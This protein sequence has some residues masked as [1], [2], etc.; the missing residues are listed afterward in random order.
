MVWLEQPPLLCTVQVKRRLES[1]RLLKMPV[2]IYGVQT[3][4]L[5]DPGAAISAVKPSFIEA[6]N[7]ATEPWNE[8]IYLA[9]DYSVQ[10]KAVTVPVNIRTPD[11]STFSGLRVL[12]LM[13]ETPVL[14]GQDVLPLLGIEVVGLPTQ[15]AEPINKRMTPSDHE[16]VETRYGVVRPLPPEELTEPQQKAR[17]WVMFQIHEVI[18][19]NVGIPGSNYCVDLD[20]IVFVD[21]GDHRPVYIRQYRLPQATWED[22]RKQIILW[23]D[24]G[25]IMYAPAG[26]E[27]NSPILAVPKKDDEG[28]VTKVRV[29]LDVRAINN[30]MP[31]RDRFPI[32]VI[33]NVL[34][35][36]AGYKFYTKIDLESGYNQFLVHPDDQVKLAF[37]FEGNQYMFVRAPF[38]LKHLPSIF[39]RVMTRTLAGMTQVYVYIDDII[40][41]AQTKEELAELTAEVVRRLTAKSLRIKPSKCIWCV[42]RV[43]VLGHWVDEHTITADPRK[44]GNV[45][46]WPQPRSAADLRAFLG[47][48]GFLSDYVPYYSALTAPMNAIKNSTSYDFTKPFTG[49]LLESWEKTK[50]AISQAVPLAFPDFSK[51]FYLATDS[52][53]VGHGGV[54]YQLN[55]D[56][57]KK[58]IRF[59][60]RS[61]TQGERGY[62]ATELELAAIRYALKQCRFYL[63]GRPFILQTDH[64]ALTFMLTQRHINRMLERC[65]TEIMDYNFTCQHIPGAKLTLPDALSRL[66]PSYAKLPTEEPLILASADTVLAMDF[67]PMFSSNDGWTLAPYVFRKVDNH[68]GYGPH[69]VDGMATPQNRQ[70]DKF[71]C[72]Q[73]CSNINDPSAKWLGP[74]EELDFSKENV[75]INPPWAKISWVLNRVLEQQSEATIIIPVW[76]NARWF[77]LLRRM[78][79][80]PPINLKHTNDLF[81]PDD[82][83]GEGVGLPNWGAT[84]A[85]RISGKPILR[86]SESKRSKINRVLTRA[87]KTAREYIPFT[88]EQK[89][90]LLYKYHQMGHF[91][92]KQIVPRLKRDGYHWPHMWDDA[93]KFVSAC[94]Q[95]AQYNSAP[96]RYRPMQ[97]IDALLPFDHLQIDCLT[98]HVSSE[99]YIGVLVIIDV[100]SR[101]CWLRPLKEITGM[102]VGKE[103]AKIMSEY[104]VCKILQSDNG[105]EFCNDVVNGVKAHMCIKERLITPWNPRCD[106]G[107]ERHIRDV[108]AMVNKM[109][110]GATMDWVHFIPQ[111]QLWMNLRITSRYGSTPFT[112]MFNRDFN[113]FQD[114]SNVQ[115]REL[116]PDEVKERFNQMQEDLFPAIYAEQAGVLARRQLNYDANHKSL[117]NPFPNGALVMLEQIPRGNKMSPKYV[118]PFKIE[119]MTR[120]GSYVIRDLLGDLFYRN[121]S[122]DQLKMVSADT[123]VVHDIDT[124]F[125]VKQILN[126]EGTPGNYRY[127]LW[128]RG[129]PKKDA[130]WE[131][132]DNLNCPDLVRDYWLRIGKAIP[133]RTGETGRERR[134]RAPNK[135]KA[136]KSNTGSNQPQRQRLDPET[137][138][139]II[140]SRADSRSDVS[141]SSSSAHVNS[142]NSNR[143]N[144]QSAAGEVAPARRSLRST[145]SSTV[146]YANLVTDDIDGLG[147]LHS[148]VCIDPANP[149]LSLYLSNESRPSIN[150]LF[151]G[152]SS[153]TA[154][155]VKSNFKSLSDIV[156]IEDPLSEVQLM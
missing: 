106:G 81:S 151:S 133:W 28:N 88:E 140:N 80:E 143:T 61:L 32:P 15:W 124:G 78:L 51:T 41:A 52:S 46:D 108:K 42:P 144:Q 95:C 116:T 146:N 20:A 156:F 82:K 76:P 139:M 91:S 64:R 102:A 1:G 135:R 25:V 7:I 11:H 34:E 31:N 66:Y 105:P 70:L 19:E 111:V 65:Y 33:R 136:T 69:T 134:P 36:L 77:P 125:E 13:C 89:E 154:A 18:K 27:W 9:S 22:V 74:V 38:G 90:E 4:A 155:F 132:G 138:N 84:L 104:G 93:H 101:F 153:S 12:P 43:E 119:R 86:L 145:R 62:S 127:K 50:L 137:G 59:V 147:R 94:L 75:Y 87:I 131:P 39:Q 97:P 142:T 53:L 150:V 118:G 117:D 96:R 54:L 122:P 24:Q 44:I 110:D 103:L 17:T 57:T 48:T 149:N 128:W 37:T 79:I 40:I 141:S 107:V 126:H 114:T 67:D 120:G 112:L 71:C 3:V 115:L 8:T 47:L 148:P 100:A 26:C 113:G 16:W 30:A 45:V 83:P 58:Y 29:C 123:E 56:G 72:L 63:W 2:T 60:A 85:C 109:L 35:E 130:T 23:Y 14:L 49:D 10:V 92:V 121:V 6:N 68:P 98:F 73:D 21:T 152:L 99:E 55:D 129:Y 5:V